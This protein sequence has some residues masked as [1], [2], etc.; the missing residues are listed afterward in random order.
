MIASF[1]EGSDTHP[2]MSRFL[3]QPSVSKPVGLSPNMRAKSLCYYRVEYIALGN[4]RK[5]PA[6]WNLIIYYLQNF[7]EVLSGVRVGLKDDDV[8]F[9]AAEYVLYIFW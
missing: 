5:V 1:W 8:L 7:V 2:A 3:N 4:N 9:D 6:G